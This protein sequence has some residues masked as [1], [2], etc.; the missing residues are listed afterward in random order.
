MPG[1]EEAVVRAVLNGAVD[2]Y[3]ELVERYQ[4]MALRVALSLLGNVEDAKD[5]SQEAFVHAYRSLR[6]F[7]Q[8]SRFSTWLYRI[9]VNA[10]KDAHRRRAR[11]P[12]VVAGV[13]QPDPQADDE[14][15]FVVDVEDPTADPGE[16]ASNR[17]L[18]GHISRAIQELPMKQRIAF[19]MHHLDGLT[20][21]EVASVMRC[22]VGTVKVHVFRATARLRV[23]LGS[24]T[25]QE[26][27]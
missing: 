11:R 13:G 9:V 2:R 24:W 5:V 4:E 10:C 21:E 1:D 19:A 23:R 20:L 3:A 25:A 26:P 17:E 6:R 12:L 18:S 27:T 16:Q 7:R 22:R 14:H 8:G 15:L